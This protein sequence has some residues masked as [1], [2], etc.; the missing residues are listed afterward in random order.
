MLVRCDHK[1]REISFNEF[2]FLFPQFTSLYVEENT[3]PVEAL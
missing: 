2:L 3:K 1:P